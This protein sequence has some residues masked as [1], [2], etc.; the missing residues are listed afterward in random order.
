M[1]SK[2]LRTC[3]VSGTILLAALLWFTRTEYFPSLSAF[4]NAQNQI[5]YNSMHIVASWFFIMNGAKRNNNLDYWV[6][7]GMGGILLTNMYTYPMAH[8]I[9]TAATLGLAVFN[10]IY[11]SRN[12]ERIV[13][14]FLGTTAI[15][16]FLVGY[17]TDMHFLLAEVIAMACV[18]IGMIRSIWV[19]N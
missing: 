19:K 7:F 6:G 9:V 12:F 3:L 10:I 5:F 14:I 4:A 15:I 2:L 11:S 16:V 17:L 18:A 13:S 8:N 1:N